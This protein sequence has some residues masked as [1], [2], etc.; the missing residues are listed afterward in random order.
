VRA[1]SRKIRSIAVAKRPFRKKCLNLPEV[2][3]Q[4]FLDADLLLG[5]ADIEHPRDC[6][7]R[8]HP[9]NQKQINPVGFTICEKITQSMSGS[10]I[11][12]R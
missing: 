8:S 9:K 5:F 2:T 1:T 12:D 4:T 6:T 11:A 7:L 10:E 3:A